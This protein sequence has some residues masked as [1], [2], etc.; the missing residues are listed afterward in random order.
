MIEIGAAALRWTALSCLASPFAVSSAMLLQSTGK[1]K[2]AS[3]LALLKNG[4]L[5]VPLI[6]ILPNYIGISG[7]EMAQPLADILTA[8]ITIPL[9]VDYLRRL[10]AAEKIENA[11]EIN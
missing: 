9:V 5:F 10:T 2:E 7:V 6:L 11:K 8:V 1:S 3:F 4:I